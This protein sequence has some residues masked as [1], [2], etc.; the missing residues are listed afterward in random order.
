MAVSHL[1]L[2]GQLSQ[3]V[4]TLGCSTLETE[5]SLPN[6]NC[7]S[8]ISINSSSEQ[9]LGRTLSLQVIV[10]INWLIQLSTKV[11]G[12]APYCG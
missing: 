4:Q 10:H 5:Q 6:G 11:D 1:V 3:T 2:H 7:Y 9:Q 8:N 12:I